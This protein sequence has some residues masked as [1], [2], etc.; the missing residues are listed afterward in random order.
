MAGQATLFSRQ[1]NSAINQDYLA[2]SVYF[3]MVCTAGMGLSK[4]F[5]KKSMKYFISKVT[6]LTF[7]NRLQFSF[8]FSIVQFCPL[9]P[10]SG[11]S[12]SSVPGRGIVL[13][14]FPKVAGN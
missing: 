9:L 14:V 3:R 6:G 10:L 13:N 2:R 12:H 5:E 8:L 7:G 11:K 4:N 1:E